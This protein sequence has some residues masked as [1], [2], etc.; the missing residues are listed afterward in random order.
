MNTIEEI[1]GSP[2]DIGTLDEFI[3]E[4][5]GIVSC[6]HQPQ[7]YSYICSF[8]DRDQLEP[9][10]EV[11]LTHKRS[12]VVGIWSDQADPLLNT[13]KVD[14]APLESYADIGGLED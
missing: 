14:K 12:N 3:D 10:S 8:V 7:Y 13:M 9:G 11:L 5:H 4:N 1:R 2:M 6:G